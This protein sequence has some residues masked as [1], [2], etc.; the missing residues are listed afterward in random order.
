MKKRDKELMDKLEKLLEQN[1]DWAAKVEGQQP[2]FFERL[3]R[4]Q[5][6]EYL[7]IG[8]TDSRV[9][10]NEIT[11]L[12]P[13][14][15]FVHR[16]IANVVVHT[17]LNCLSVIQFAVDVLKVKH[18]VVLGHAQ[19]GGIKTLV[20]PSAPLSPSDFIGK[21]MSL[22]SSTLDGDPRKPGESDQDYI[23]RIEKKAVSTSLDNLMTFPCV[24][25]QVERGKM[26]LHGAYF[27]VAHGSLSILDRSTGDFQTVTQTLPVGYESA[28]PHSAPH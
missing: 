23:T 10:A 18:I 13:G 24:K 6:P 12:L 17:D 3:A 28:R 25:I 19:C 20:H 27:G 11:G 4:L 15:V 16:N 26:Q 21:W 7:W 22:L 2:G 8:C 5:A 9:P 1:A 14:E